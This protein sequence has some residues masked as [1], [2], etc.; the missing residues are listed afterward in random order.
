MEKKKTSPVV[1]M[2]L[3]IVIVAAGVFIFQ[4]LRQ[5]ADDKKAIQKDFSEVRR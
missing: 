3:L 2:V 1:Y 5:N 4:R